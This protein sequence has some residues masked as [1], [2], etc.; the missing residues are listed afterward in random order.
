VA[1]CSGSHGLDLFSVSAPT[2]EVKNGSGVISSHRIETVSESVPV[3]AASEFSSPDPEIPTQTVLGPE[4]PSQNP[5]ARLAFG[6]SRP[7]KSAELKAEVVLAHTKDQ[8]REF[9]LASRPAVP[10]LLLMSS[11]TASGFSKSYLKCATLVHT[12][13]VVSA[14]ASAINSW[15]KKPSPV[16]VFSIPPDSREEAKA[17]STLASLSPSQLSMLFQGTCKGESVR[18]LFDSGASECF[19]GAKMSAKVGGRFHA[20]KFKS[21]RLASGSTVQVQGSVTFPLRLGPLSDYYIQ[22]L[23]AL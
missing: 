23:A 21:V 16:L 4:N 8:V 13:P 17:S 14:L 11:R 3:S 10:T 5:K 15:Q 2:P 6:V 19:I 20:S 22:S 1:S 9:F 12:Y 7:H 18:V